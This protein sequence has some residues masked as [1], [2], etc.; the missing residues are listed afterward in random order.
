M[1]RR[2]CTIVVVLCFA[3]LCLA[4]CGGAT[5]PAS[6][7]P[8]TAASSS[9]PAAAPTKVPT[10]EPTATTPPTAEP[11]VAPTQPTGLS[12]TK[13]DMN[14]PIFKAYFAVYNK[15]PRRT[16]AEVFNP[17]TQQTSTVLIETDAKDHLSLEV[18]GMSGTNGITMS[19][20]II[21]P[22]TYLKQGAT[23]QKLPGAQSGMMLGMLTDADSLQQLLNAFGE[24]ASYTVMP[25]GPED[26]NGV[27]AMAY[28]SEFTLK[29]GKISK[30]KAWIGPDGLLTRDHIETSDGAVVTT[31]YEFDPNIKVEAPIP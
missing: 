25:V 3:A 18:N 15:F 28:S 10:P 11:T 2:I 4:A 20:V 23:W 30:S 29:D 8:T 22:T 9:Q 31:T 27:P 19:I 21:S 14:N 12:G 26:I 24:L 7:A 5:Q 17:K 16:R 1:S 13:I 6:T